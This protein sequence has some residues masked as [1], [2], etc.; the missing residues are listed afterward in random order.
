MVSE[1]TKVA[2][3]SDVPEGTVKVFEVGAEQIAVCNAGGTIYAVAD[4]CSHD[5]GPLDQGTLEGCEIECP[6]HGARFDIKTGQALCLPAVMPIPTYKV[7][8][9]GQEIWVGPKQ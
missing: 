7:E 1:F 6:R 4:L 8:T 5:N 2:N 3:I 9:R